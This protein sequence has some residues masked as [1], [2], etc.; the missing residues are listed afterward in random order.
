[1]GYAILVKREKASPPTPQDEHRFSL[2]KIHQV[3]QL[4]LLQLYLRDVFE[5][6]YEYPVP[7]AETKI[8]LI[9]EG[10][11][12]I[13]MDFTQIRAEKSSDSLWHIYLPKP[14]VCHFKLNHQKSRIYDA[15]F[16]LIETFRQQHS[17]IIEDMFRQ[18]EKKL[19]EAA[20]FTSYQELAY[21]QAEKILRSFLGSF[22]VRVRFY[23][24]NEKL[25]ALRKRKGGP[26]PEKSSPSKT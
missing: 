5:R 25:P 8:L 10:E 16:S 20:L 22:E 23:R 7:F 15:N 19:A 21:L 2:E 1:M 26:Q 12:Q 18:A 17:Q 13:C 4:T 9:A 11:A 24:S 6:K 14:K 3:G